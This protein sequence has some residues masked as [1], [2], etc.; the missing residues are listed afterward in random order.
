M[1]RICECKQKSISSVV[2]G[3]LVLE[4]SEEASLG[5]LPL[6]MLVNDPFLIFEELSVLDEGFMDIGLAVSTSSTVSVRMSFNGDTGVG[7]STSV[8][9]SLSVRVGVG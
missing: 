7:M 5:L 1:N 9:V 8:N 2:A 3:D 4:V 6:T